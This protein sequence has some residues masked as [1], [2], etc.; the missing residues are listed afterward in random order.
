M[1]TSAINCTDA[2]NQTTNNNKRKFT[3]HK[4]TN[5][6]KNKLVKTKIHIGPYTKP[7]PYICKNCSYQCA[8]D[9]TQLCYTIQHKKVLI[10]FP[11]IP[12]TIIIARMLSNGGEGQTT[13]NEQQVCVF[14]QTIF[15]SLSAAF[16]SLH[17]HFH[18]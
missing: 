9:C 13:L 14:Y 18:G 10:V 7:K 5:R 11:L 17:G 16:T 15:S 3:K 2:D 12:Q 8:Y 4:I 6:N 1:H